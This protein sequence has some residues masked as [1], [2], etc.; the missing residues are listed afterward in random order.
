MNK[1]LAG[2]LLFATP[3]WTSSCSLKLFSGKKKHKTT[4]TVVAAQALV[5]TAH[6]VPEQ[7]PVQPKDG[8]VMSGNAAMNQL[9]SD[10]APVFSKRIPYATFS[11]KAKV[12]FEGPDASNDFTANF[13][14]RKDSVIWVQVTVLGGAVS[15]AR[16][17]VTRDSFFLI[18]YIQ[19][20]VTKIALKDAAKTLP[21]AVDFTQ[22]QNL[23]V[24][25]PLRDGEITAVADQ[26]A[27]W[28]LT[29][30]DSSYVQRLS[31]TKSDSTMNAGQL[32]T[33]KPGGP[34]AVIDYADYG[35]VD[36]RKVAMKRS[37]QVQ[38]AEKHY[39]IDMNF[40]SAQFDK[41]L[42]YPF[43]IPKNYSLKN[44]K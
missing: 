11:G 44:P 43:S 9:I 27:A 31:Y 14:V 25:D 40:T 13:R 7:P 35:M 30:E 8:S 41:P 10:L 23:I 38:N 36:N 15:A 3:I 17:L 4:D 32:T 24:G 26:V 12:N 28:L 1:Y 19:K 42:E 22:L 20:E 16:M 33:R 37:V 39:A 34:Q 21:T 2:V 18:N 29:V 5:D 6:A